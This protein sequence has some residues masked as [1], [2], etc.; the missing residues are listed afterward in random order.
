MFISSLMYLSMLMLSIFLI[1]A[2]S[3]VYTYLDSFDLTIYKETLTTVINKLLSG[4]PYELC[5]LTDS[6]AELRIL[7][8]LRFFFT[9]AAQLLFFSSACLFFNF[10][11]DSRLPRHPLQV[12]RLDVFLAWQ[13]R[14]GFVFGF[15][16]SAK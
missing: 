6:W 2:I 12:F 4:R 13:E 3:Y 15:V 1:Y 9:D 8:E 5:K 16:I 11:L 14:H 7:L 10:C